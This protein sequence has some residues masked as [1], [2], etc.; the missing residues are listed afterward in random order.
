MSDDEMST[1]DVRD[2]CITRSRPV[3]TVEV[4]KSRPTIRH[5]DRDVEA[6]SQQVKQ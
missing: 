3:R 4:N 6:Y 2:Y 5:C 1:I